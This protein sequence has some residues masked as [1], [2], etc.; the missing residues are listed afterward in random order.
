MGEG[1]GVTRRGR[2]ALGLWLVFGLLA[3]RCGT[4]TLADIK[5]VQVLREQRPGRRID[6]KLVESLLAEPVTPNVFQ[7]PWKYRIDAGV[8]ERRRYER[9]E[10]R[11]AAKVEVFQDAIEAAIER[12]DAE[13]LYEAVKACLAVDH[14]ESTGHAALWCARSGYGGSIRLGA[15]Q[16]VFG[17]LLVGRLA[18]EP[19]GELHA[20]ADL[21]FEM[22]Y[23]L[24]ERSPERAKRRFQE[25]REIL[26][27]AG[28]SYDERRPQPRSVEEVD[29]WIAAMDRKRKQHR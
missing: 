19:G 21:Q 15:N 13:G 11:F 7:G 24:V 17:D 22:G 16:E 12:R 23:R 9:E 14:G 6:R 2:V 28:P 29:G 5:Y 3:W 26:V 20:R 8:Y 27:R 18:L 25:A 10:Q 4:E 1:H